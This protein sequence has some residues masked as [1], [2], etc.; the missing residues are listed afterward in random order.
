MELRIV[1]WRRDRRHILN[2]QQSFTRIIVIT[3]SCVI[4]PT[5][6]EDNVTIYPGATILGGETIIG[7]NSTVGGNVFLIQSVPVNSLVIAEDVSVK[8]MKKADNYDI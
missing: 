5:T 1:D 6:I 3:S 8:V 7:A 2:V 4:I